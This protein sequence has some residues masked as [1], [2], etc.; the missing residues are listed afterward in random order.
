MINQ[1]FRK[2]IP[3]EMLIKILACYNL[4]S[5]SDS[6]IFTKHDLIL[7]NTVKRLY[8]I[9]ETLLQYYLPCKR[10]LYL[11]I[12][13]LSKCMTILR[14]VIR[15]YNYKLNKSEKYISKK[16]TTAYQLL[17]I[18]NDAAFS[19]INKTETIITFD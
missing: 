13:T 15:L 8:E 1:L 17:P 5:L 2:M 10:H 19:V 18:N 14:Q 16:K 3:N 11:N 9:R 7:H 6:K 12:I 4:K